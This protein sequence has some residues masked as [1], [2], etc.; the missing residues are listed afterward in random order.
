MVWIYFR[1]SGES[2]THCKTGLDQLPTAKSNHSAKAYSCKE[3]KK[4]ICP[5]HQFGTILQHYPLEDFQMNLLKE[6]LTSYM[7]GFRARTSLLQELEKR[8]EERRVGKE[9]RSRWSQ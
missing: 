4:G 9:C 3:C 7:E 8:S 2:H 5:K 1:E 6:I